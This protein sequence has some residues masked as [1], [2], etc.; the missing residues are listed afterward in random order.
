MKRYK[1]LRMGFAVV[2]VCLVGVLP[3]RSQVPAFTD[4]TGAAGIANSLY[5][6]GLA[7]ADYDGDGDLDL[8]VT[9]WTFTGGF[10][11]NKL[12][13]N[14]GGGAFTNVASSLNVAGFNNYSSSASWADFNNDGRLDL[15]VTNFTRDEQDVL[16]QNNGTSFSILLPNVVKG[17]PRWSAWGDYDLD[18]DLDLYL[19]RY[20]GPN[21]LYQN[22]GNGSFTNVPS[23]TTGIHDYRDSE[24]VCWIDY[25]GDGYPDLFIVNNYQEN[26]LYRNQ[27]DGSFEDVTVASGLGGAGQ[28]RHCAWADY[29]NDGDM[30][31][32]VANIGANVLYSNEGESFERQTG[33]AA[34]TASAWRSW[35]AGWAD[36]NLDGTPDLFIASGA[37]SENGERRILFA[38]NGDGT[39]TDVTAAPFTAAK[40]GAASAWGDYDNDGDA[41]LY[42]T[43]Y[44]PDE[45]F[46]NDTVP[47]PGQTFLKIRPFR[48]GSA[49]GIGA[50]IWVFDGGT[51]TLRAYHEIVSG[52]DA[53]EAIFG[54]PAAGSYDVKVQFTSRTGTPGG[55]VVIDKNDDAAKYGAVTIPR[56]LVV[57]EN[58]NTIIP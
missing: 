43:N 47:N 15:Y 40:S 2:F 8:F 1:E 39:L 9:A 48:L 57:E 21:L 41:D 30:D 22:N 33:E 36:Y 52:A 28:G 24:R 29:D 35:F 4:V 51:T 55:A 56:T 7:W 46:R 13:R 26:R 3:A 16:Y 17:N 42:V 19:A 10:P 31:L 6:P 44:G 25:D 27:G 37:E 38:N 14:D 5:S 12:W 58:E 23:G 34:Q 49:D 32:Y 18:G 54:L 50:R 11:I 20:N 53:L 45:L